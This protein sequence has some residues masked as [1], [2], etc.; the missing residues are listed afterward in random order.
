MTSHLIEMRVDV[1][2]P[3]ALYDAAKARWRQDNPDPE[4]WVDMLDTLRPDGEIDI[5]ACLIMLADP[6]LS[7]PGTDI[8]D[9]ACTL[10][11]GLGIA[12]E[13]AHG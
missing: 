10:Q 6:G 8:E 1:F 9:S 5:N 4:S 12:G 11:I 7:W 3:Q 13:S 2:D